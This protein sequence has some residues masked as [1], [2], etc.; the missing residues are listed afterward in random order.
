[1]GKGG[2][3]LMARIRS[4]HPGLFT[5]E[6]F[7]SLSMAARVFVPGLWTE[8]DDHGVFEWKPISLKMKLFAADNVDVGALLD[9]LLN[10]DMVQKFEESGKSFGV[11]RNFCRY[12]RP[13]KP[14]YRYPFPH[15]CGTY[16]GLIY[17]STEPVP[18]QYPTSTE[19]SPQMEDG[20]GNRREEKERKN[21]ASAGSTP[22][23]FE[24]GVIRLKQ[25]D[26]DQW[27]KA[28]SHLDLRAELLSLSEWAAKQKKWFPAVSGALAKRNREMALRLEQAR[29]PPGL[30]THV[31]PRL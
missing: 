5:D 25:K 21:P 29:A 17:S 2:I 16:V 22:V 3:F 14:S 26:F 7:V 10:A 1:M 13:K 19:K 23:V 30:I 12:Q 27:E 20:G 11:V 24:S 4:V 15:Q 8:C 18:H 28:F 9:E 31:D 6:A